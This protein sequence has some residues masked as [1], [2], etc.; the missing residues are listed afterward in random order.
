MAVEGSCNHVN[1]MSAGSCTAVGVQDGLAVHAVGV[2]PSLERDCMPWTAGF[3]GAL[4]RGSAIPERMISGFCI[5][6]RVYEECTRLPP[7]RTIGSLHNRAYANRPWSV[8]VSLSA[9]FPGPPAK[10]PGNLNARACESVASTCRL[11]QLIRGSFFEL[12]WIASARPRQT[13]PGFQISS[14]GAPPASSLLHSC[15]PVPT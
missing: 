2:E 3:D 12:L 9:R 1:C 4:H 8:P 7:N 10:P 15:L 14:A 13:V 5:Y 6:T 11:R